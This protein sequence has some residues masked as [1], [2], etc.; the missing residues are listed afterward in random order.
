[1]KH[2]TVE[3]FSGSGT[4]SKAISP[5]RFFKITIDNRQRKNV[6]EPDYKMDILKIPVDSSIFSQAH[7]LWFGLPC[8]A[9]SNASGNFHINKS[10][11]LISDTAKKSASILAHAINIINYN[12]PLYWVIENPRGRLQKQNMMIH[13]LETYPGVIKNFSMGS[14]GFPSQKPTQLFTNWYNLKLPN[15]LPYGRG[16][17]SNGNF[18]NLTVCQRQ[19]YPVLFCQHIA[20]QLLQTI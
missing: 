6:C 5:A 16:A 13:F 20:N 8:T 10:G 18:D 2:K 11:I 19:K 1:M 3:I 17:K 15:S 7:L 9:W 14:F 4:L 12:R